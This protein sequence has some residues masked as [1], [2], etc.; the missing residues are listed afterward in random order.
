MQR[1]VQRAG[2]DAMTV[3]GELLGD[4]GAVDLTFSGVMEH[5]QLHG[6]TIER[7]H[8]SQATGDASLAVR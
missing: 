8:G 4:P 7:A 6:P 3:A 1:G 2:A 5:V